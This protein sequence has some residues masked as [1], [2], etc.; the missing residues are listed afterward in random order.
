MAADLR[1]T[2]QAQALSDAMNNE[3][4][5]AKQRYTNAYKA[6]Q[7]RRASS[8]GTGVTGGTGGTTPANNGNTSLWDGEIDEVDT[9]E[10]GE[11]TQNDSGSESG[12]QKK[13][14]PP[15]VEDYYKDTREIEKKKQEQSGMPDWLWNVMKIFG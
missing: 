9:G 1:A 2:A 3:L 8:G 12:A 11:K 6:Y 14:T 7:K 15:K 13:T 4:A 10:E 5:Q